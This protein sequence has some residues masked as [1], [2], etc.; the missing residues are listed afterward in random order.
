MSRWRPGAAVLVAWLFG[1]G[2]GG[3]GGSRLKREERKEGE[4][5]CEQSLFWEGRGR[6]G[7]H[8]QATQG[9]G[10]FNEKIF[11]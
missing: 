9:C 7:R 10:K 6:K 8:A 5:E 2:G 3:V 1:V 4:R 11:M